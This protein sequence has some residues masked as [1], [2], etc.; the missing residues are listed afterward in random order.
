M[1]SKKNVLLLFVLSTFFLS[2]KKENDDD[3]TTPT[4]ASASYPDYSQLHVGNYWIY[5]R[6]D[7]DSAGGN[8]TATGELDSCYIEKDTVVNGNIYY[9]FRR[10]SSSS[11]W[12]ITEY[13]RDS[14]S[15][16]VDL[17]GRIV[18][19]SQDY[20]SIFFDYYS[21]INGTDTIYHKVQQMADINGTTVVPAGTFTTLNSKSTY[22]MY[23]S[24][25]ATGAERPIHK[26]Y[27][28]NIGLVL[29]SLPFFASSAA[30]SER[31]LVRYHLN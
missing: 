11:V 31:R 24:W 21:I 23:G 6:F 20:W 30:Y 9:K 4:P 26:K 15:Y 10:P 8:E 14:L 19:S 12:D 16:T 25:A 5:E 17:N 1:K 27:A 3:D 29:E 2:C 28:Q 22:Y 7:I 13:L 18:F